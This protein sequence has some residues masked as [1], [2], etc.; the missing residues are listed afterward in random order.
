LPDFR[1]RETASKA[2]TVPLV[3]MHCLDFWHPIS[4]FGMIAKVAPLY[5]SAVIV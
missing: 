3:P 1:D 4:D 5:L 2:Q